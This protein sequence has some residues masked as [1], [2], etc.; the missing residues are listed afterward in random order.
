[1]DTYGA[2]N[3]I[4][5]YAIEVSLGRGGGSHR[6][7]VEDHDLPIQNRGTYAAPVIKPINPRHKQPLTQILF[8][9]ALYLFGAG[10]PVA[11]PIAA[12]KHRS[13]ALDFL[14]I[15]ASVLGG[16]CSSSRARR[17][18]RFN[19]STDNIPRW[20]FPTGFHVF[21]RES[22]SQHLSAVQRLNGETMERKKTTGFAGNCRSYADKRNATWGALVPRCARQTSRVES[23]EVE[24]SVSMHVQAAWLGVVMHGRLSNCSIANK[25]AAQLESASSYARITTDPSRRKNLH[26]NSAREPFRGTSYEHTETRSSRGE[27]SRVKRAFRNTGNFLLRGLSNFVDGTIRP[28]FPSWFLSSVKFVKPTS[29]LS[30]NVR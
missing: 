19:R 13:F 20:D 30:F 29:K 9:L 2:E 4:T 15:I 6:R 12:D 5:L 28:R 27:V 10:P 11:C 23:S 24:S 26:A 16:R 7:G 14:V 1:M 8:S 18:W 3:A 22:S 21:S 25:S 17:F